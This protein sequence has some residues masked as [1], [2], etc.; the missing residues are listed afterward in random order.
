LSWQT[1]LADVA[2]AI[3]TVP[4]PE[5]SARIAVVLNGRLTCEELALA[6]GLFVAGLGLSKVYFADRTPGS[7]DGLLLTA[8]R[9]PNGRGVLEAGFTPRLPAL[10]EIAAA[11]VLLV[12][13]TYL[14]E[15][16]AEEAL[17]RA[18]AGIRSKF[19][20]SAHAG[21]LDRLADIV[22]PVAVPAERSGTYINVDGTRQTF[23]QAVKP[24]AGVAAES[25]ILA[26]LANSLAPDAGGG[27]AR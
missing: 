19:L 13:G 5:R 20:F 4:G 26:G 11:D 1:A 22:F 3:R 16:F 10:G 12:F 25:A 2:A 21:S 23:A 17:A 18:W 24:V 14:S 9:L 8:E 7:A 27:D 15:H 6:K